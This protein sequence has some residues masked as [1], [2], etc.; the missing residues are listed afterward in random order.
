MVNPEDNEVNLE[1]PGLLDNTPGRVAG[2]SRNYV[3]L[4]LGRQGL[5]K[6]AHGVGILALQGHL[7]GRDDVE[8]IQT[9]IEPIS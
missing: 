3:V 9:G 1:L 2:E 5:A 7:C 4:L 6:L 8:N